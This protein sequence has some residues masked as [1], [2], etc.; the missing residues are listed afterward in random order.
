V[1]RRLGP[2]ARLSAVVAFLL[3]C[4]YG[5]IVEGLD[6]SRSA[7]TPAQKIAAA[8]QLLYG[9]GAAAALLARLLLRRW[10]L[11]LLLVWGAA[12]T[13]TGG[14]APVVWGEQG[15]AVGLVAAVAVAAVVALVLWACR[16]DNASST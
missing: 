8:S 1:R 3:L 12:L 7:S 11:P 10:S 14:L 16:S 15:P 13:V 4:A 9:A 6:A 2:L 5:G